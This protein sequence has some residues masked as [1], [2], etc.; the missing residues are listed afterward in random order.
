MT[1]QVE[2]HLQ[3]GT[4]ALDAVIEGGEEPVTLIGPNGA[5]KSTLLRCI[6]GAHRPESGRIS[7]NGR[8]LFDST[9]DICLPP[10]ERRLGYLP[11]GYGLFP[12]LRVVDNVS[13]G[14]L[15]TGLEKKA[16]V[17]AAMLL[18][19]ELD[20]TDLALK[21]PSALSGGEKQRIALARTLA[22]QAQ[23]LLL[24][25]PLTSLDALVRHRLRVYLEEHL[26]RRKIPSLLVSH[27]LRDV[28]AFG[29]LVYVLEKGQI[30]QTG[31]ARDLAASPKTDFVSAFFCGS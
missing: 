8:T 23:F 11:Q 3:L 19:D 18:L 12:H 20:S 24:D 13:F 31:R 10:E 9:V 21:Y 2:V 26:S 29:S 28:M 7:L 1:W 6:A 14:L 15:S 5:G 22:Y 27:D 4:L 17:E 16:R 25:E 30:V